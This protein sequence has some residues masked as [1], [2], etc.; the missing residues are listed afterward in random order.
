SG[1]AVFQ[2][3]EVPCRNFPGTWS[4]APDADD[5]PHKE[6]LRKL[7]HATKQ[8][9]QLDQLGKDNQQLVHQVAALLKGLNQDQPAE[10]IGICVLQDGK[11]FPG[12]ERQCQQAGGSWSYFLPPPMTKKAKG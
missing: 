2:A 11:C 3:T 6:L 12:T 8:L 10:R 4:Y 9:N 7:P 1:G 5:S